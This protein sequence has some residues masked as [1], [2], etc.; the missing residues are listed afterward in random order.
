MNSCGV[1]AYSLVRPSRSR[2]TTAAGVRYHLREW[3][4]AEAPPL[5]LLHGARDTSAS[6]QFIVDAL[7]GE[8]H[9]VAPDWRGHGQSDWG[10]GSYWFSDFLSDLDVFVTN[11]FP[12][13][14]VPLI[15]HSMGGN[16]AGV[17]AGLR[18]SRV[19]QLVILD[20]LGNPLDRSP[21]PMDETLIELLDSKVR[22][23]KVRSYKNLA[24]MT[25][26]LLRAN[27]RLDPARAA[28]LAASNAQQLPDGGFR[29]AWDPAFRKS[30]PTLHST[31][32]WGECWRRIEA[33]VLCLLSSDTRPNAA[34]SDSG[35]VSERASYF[36]NLTLRTVPDT[37]HN[38]H[39]DAP[40]FVAHAIEAF[41]RV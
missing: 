1:P 3:G 33:P 6:F 17:Y 12:D 28:F 34:T 10:L 9:V 31:S 37:G 4:P 41:I 13:R 40:Q 26:K 16:I 35:A 25:E 5:L 18:S 11:V 7:V 14:P 27:H 19:A 32:E 36:R 29:W 15:G 38:L 8:W 24:E 39:H 20:A 30:W 23:S 22:H 21:V 2:F